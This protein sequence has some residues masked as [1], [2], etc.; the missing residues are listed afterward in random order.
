MSALTPNYRHYTHHMSLWGDKFQNF[1]PIRTLPLKL[2]FLESFVRRLFGIKFAFVDVLREPIDVA[3][4]HQS[5]KDLVLSASVFEQSHIAP[6]YREIF[7][8]PSENK[9]YKMAISIVS[10]RVKDIPVFLHCMAEMYKKASIL[11]IQDYSSNPKWAAI[12][13]SIYKDTCNCIG[14]IENGDNTRCCAIDCVYNANPGYD[15]YRADMSQMYV[16]VYT[17]PK[18]KVKEEVKEKAKEKEKEEK[19]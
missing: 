5:P 6:K 7:F 12:C 2:S 14:C 10:I 11:N 18:E 16:N 1:I 8:L 13:T 19:S 3:D 9:E 17:L 15:G 4:P